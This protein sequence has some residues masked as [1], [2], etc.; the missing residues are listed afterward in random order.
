MK[1]CK[2]VARIERSEIR[3]FLIDALLPD[4]APLNP[5]YRSKISP[6]GEQRHW[7]KGCRA[8]A[9]FEMQ[10]RRIDVTGLT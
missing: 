3:V 8:F 9:H 7:V 10:L 1:Q 5:G 4:F 6:A 2:I